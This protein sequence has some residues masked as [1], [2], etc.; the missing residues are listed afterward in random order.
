[1]PTRL[2]LGAGLILATASMPARAQDVPASPA[3]HVQAKPGADDIVVEGLLPPGEL[4]TQLRQGSNN[5]ITNRKTYEFSLRV[6]KC[7]MRLPLDRLRK[8]IDGAPN[9]A[10]QREAQA[11][12]ARLTASCNADPW[13]ASQINPAGT[14]RIWSNIANANQNSVTDQLVQA[15]NPLS[16]TELSAMGTS[17]Y[18]HGAFLETTIKR[19]APD[20]SLT[21]RETSDPAVQARFNA[22]EIPRNSFRLEADLK[23]FRVA[24]CMVRMQPELSVRLLNAK[25]GS[26]LQRLLQAN[27]LSNARA[28]VGNAKRVY[29]EP[30]QFRVYIIDAL[31][32]W[33]IAA[34]AVPS[35]IPDDVTAAR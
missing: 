18:D 21:K 1:M 7:A 10:S 2:T 12:I 32:R 26:N 29:V 9:S 3:P 34:R 15:G 5:A 14:T 17:L 33:V 13:I 8:A 23:Y 24:V 11:T 35:L 19:F 30:T 22:V 31:Y 25:P 6:A 4:P 20:I 28:C 16:P 27:I